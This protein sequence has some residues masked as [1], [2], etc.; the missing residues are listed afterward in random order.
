VIEVNHGRELHLLTLAKIRD[1]SELV[2]DNLLDRSQET[3]GVGGYLNR[4]SGF[5]ELAVCNRIMTCTLKT[6]R[7]LLVCL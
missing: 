6:I 2:E 3:I 4:R 5:S 1:F 7:T